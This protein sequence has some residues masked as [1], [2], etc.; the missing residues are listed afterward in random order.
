MYMDLMKFIFYLL[1]I[2]ITIYFKE[3]EIY[4]NQLTTQKP[5]FIIQKVPISNVRGRKKFKRK[6]TLNTKT[7]FVTTNKRKSIQKTDIDLSAKKQ[8]LDVETFI[9]HHFAHVSIPEWE[10]AFKITRGKPGC[11]ISKCSKIQEAFSLL[12]DHL[13]LPLFCM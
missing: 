10:F 8:K 1:F 2:V 7:N 4:T 11:A 3:R 5:N 13:D 9:F 6:V 12:E